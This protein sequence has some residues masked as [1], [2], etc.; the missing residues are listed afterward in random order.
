MGSVLQLRTPVFAFA[1]L[2]VLA[3][4]SNA[5]AGR[6]GHSYAVDAPTTLG[7][8]ASACNVSARALAEAN[9]GVDPAD[10]RPGQHLAVPPESSRYASVR[11]VRSITLE[12]GA[13]VGPRSAHPYIVSPGYASS[14]AEIGSDIVIE[15]IA[16][17]ADNT[18]TIRV[19]DSRISGAA[20][21]WLQSGAPRGGHYAETSRLSY[22]QQSAVRI[23]SAN[24]TF[25]GVD[26]TDAEIVE[27]AGVPAAR[28]TE[29][30][31]TVLVPAPPGYRLPDYDAIGK[32]PHSA[33]FRQL[34]FSLTG[35]IVDEDD[36]CLT[37]KTAN[38]NVWLLA[39]APAAP[40][41]M[42]KNVTVWGV[43]GAAASCGAGP[44]MLV[45]HTV[46]AEPW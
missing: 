21:S 26:F 11:A 36:G 40:D 9:P 25:A 32:L 18:V 10:V 28:F 35:E 1:G 23:R 6:C 14:A 30:P 3:A 44:S 46:Y 24:R 42:G 16:P 19:R 41:M 22:Q 20:P 2:A 45:S 33:A 15:K 7:K 31:A 4:A 13:N 8:V 39:A 34:K 29:E 17:A 38:N 27:V 37:L 43:R 5:E 12:A